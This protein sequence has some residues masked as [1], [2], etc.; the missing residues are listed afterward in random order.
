MSPRGPPNTGNAG[1]PRVALVVG[2]T[3]TARIEGISAAGAD[4]DAMVRTPAADAELVTYGSPVLAP[5]VPAS[6]TG[7]PTPALVTRAA[8]ELVGFEPLIVDAGLQVPTAAPTLSTGAAPGGDVRAAAPVPDAAEVVST[9][10]RYAGALPGDEIVVGESVPGGTT[11]ALGVLAALGEDYAVSSSLPENP[12]ARKREVVAAGLA[13]SGIAE[14]DLAGDPVAALR[15]MGD[16][17]LAA[18]FGLADGALAAGTAVTLAGG[19]QLL[20]VAGL[21]RHDGVEVPLRVATTSY[22]AGDDSADV[23]GAADGFDVDL[24]VTDPGFDEVTSEGSGDVPHVAL[25]RYRAGE[26][27][28]GAAMG[29]ALALADRRGVPMADVRERVAGLYVRLLGGGG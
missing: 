5:E 17:V 28:E 26:A 8:R 3:E 6:P 12:L 1:P 27:K 10:R 29:G 21:L 25:G 4:P 7:C 23:R 14:G 24:V 11:T 16:P 13:E 18:V 22:V 20:A 2:S 15:S 19:T 9:A